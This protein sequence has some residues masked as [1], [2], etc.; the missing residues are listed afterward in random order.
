MDSNLPKELAG[1][2]GTLVFLNGPAIND[3]GVFL[4]QAREPGSILVTFR[5]GTTTVLETIGIQECVI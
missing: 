2:E 3:Y 4:R 1:L 5:R